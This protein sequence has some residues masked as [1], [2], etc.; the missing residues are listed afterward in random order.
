MHTTTLGKNGPTVSALGLGCMG[1]SAGI[2]G[3]A[4]DASPIE[5]GRRHH[6]SRSHGPARGGTTLFR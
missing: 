1:M 4:D 6:N 3:P 5:K 2:Y